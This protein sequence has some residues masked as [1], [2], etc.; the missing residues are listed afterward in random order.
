ML[1]RATTPEPLTP[2]G[3]SNM[4]QHEL[5]KTGIRGMFRF[6]CETACDQERERGTG[7]PRAVVGTAR[8][9]RGKEKPRVGSVGPEGGG[10]LLIEARALHPRRSCRS[11][12]TT[13]ST[14]DTEEREMCSFALTRTFEPSGPASGEFI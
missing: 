2:S 10:L 1:L 8:G 5:Q 13:E 3:P 7:K 9:R 11:Q 12:F 14:E 4:W 6:Q